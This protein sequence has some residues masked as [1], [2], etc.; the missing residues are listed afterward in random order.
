MNNIGT[1]FCIQCPNFSYL[2]GPNKVT[3]VFLKHIS[4]IPNL[5]TRNL[6]FCRTLPSQENVHGR[7]RRQL[8]HGQS[9]LHDW[10]PQ[11][12]AYVF[13]RRR[14][15]QHGLQQ[16]PKVFDL[17]GGLLCLHNAYGC[18][19][20]MTSEYKS[21]LL[22][23]LLVIAMP[24]SHDSGRSHTF[25]VSIFP[26]WVLL[27]SSSHA[28]WSNLAVPAVLPTCFVVDFQTFG[29]HVHQMTTSYFGISNMHFHHILVVFI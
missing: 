14:R 13:L 15:M 22:L 9:R 6:S 18:L 4:I 7:L 16:P 27:Q 10:R 24:F 11:A 5:D 2:V 19:S 28:S 26:D 3:L 12:R 23:L 17:A 29:L 21:P 25:Y 8:L 1:Y 20:T